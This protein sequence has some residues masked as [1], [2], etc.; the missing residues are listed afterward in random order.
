MS[1]TTATA[2]ATAGGNPPPLL[3]PTELVSTITTVLKSSNTTTSALHA[4][5]S[6]Y[7]PHLT[8]PVIHSILSSPALHH[9]PSAVLVFLNW[10]HS[11]ST[12]KSFTPLPL[13]PLISLLSTLI[14]HHK[15][16]DAKSILQ[17]QIS[18][19]HPHHQLHRHLLHPA[20]PLP[21]PSK[22]LLNTCIFAYCRSGWPHLAA[23][24]FQENEAP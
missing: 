18:A 6:P 20:P 21:P 17:S 11:Q 8:P 1:T 22:A 7:L 15:F 3:N 23:Q 24:I 2:T 16:D 13:P 4:A 14:S 9:Q 5:L 19:E 10:A 12:V